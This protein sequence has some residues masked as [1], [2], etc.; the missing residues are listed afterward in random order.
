MASLYR[1]WE[2]ASKKRA[3]PPEWDNWEDCRA[4]VITNRYKMEYGYKG[5]FSPQGCAKAMPGYVEPNPTA[6]TEEK[7]E[8]DAGKQTKPRTRR[9][10]SV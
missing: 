3:L 9:R 6:I 2:E 5:E 7:G 8:S 4:W 1:T 10:N